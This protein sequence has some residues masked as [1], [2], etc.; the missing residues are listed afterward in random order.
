MQHVVLRA[1]WYEGTT[2]ILYLTE[3]EIAFI[4]ALFYWLDNKPDEGKS[5]TGV[6]G[7]NPDDELQKMSHT[8]ARIFK[9]QTRLEPAQQH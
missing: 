3:F 8:K 6:P 4:L 5:E 1:T 2:Q 7:E 9:R